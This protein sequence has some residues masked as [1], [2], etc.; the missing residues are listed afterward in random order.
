MRF[1]KNTALKDGTRAPPPVAPAG[2]AVP[3]SVASLVSVHRSNKRLCF[4]IERV[5]RTARLTSGRKNSDNSWSLTYGELCNVS[6]L[7]ALGATQPLSLTL[8]VLG[9]ESGETIEVF[10]VPLAAGDAAPGAE[11]KPRAKKDSGGN[12]CEQRR[13]AQRA[14]RFPTAGETRRAGRETDCIGRDHR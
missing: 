11:R 8:R 9:V 1:D 6:Y 4:R 12:S 13:G 2:D 10:E 3:L 5:P 7:P 14:P